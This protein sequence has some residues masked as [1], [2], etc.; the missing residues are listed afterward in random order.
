VAVKVAVLTAPVVV[1]VPEPALKL[2]HVTPAPEIAL[3][4]VSVP[5]LT[6]PVVAIVPEPVFRDETVLDH[7][8]VPE[9]FV[10]INWPDVP[11][12]FGNVNVQVA[13]LDGVVMAMLFVSEAL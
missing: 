12:L 4:A 1:I 7:D 10:T 9:P 13:V 5:V 8:D 2:V 11:A 6:A 3:V